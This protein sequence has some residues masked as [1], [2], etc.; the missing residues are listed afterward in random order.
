VRVCVCFGGGGREGG[1]EGKGKRLTQCSPYNSP[2]AMHEFEKRHVSA[3][4]WFIMHQHLLVPQQQRT[5]ASTARACESPAI[6]TCVIVE[7]GPRSQCCRCPL[8]VAAAAAAAA[9]RRC[10]VY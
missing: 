5:T 1:G 8:A 2:M 4:P 9:S 6:V 10:H 7:T 3:A